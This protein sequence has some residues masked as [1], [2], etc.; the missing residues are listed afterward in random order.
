MEFDEQ[1]SQEE[2]PGLGEQSEQPTEQE[3]STQHSIVNQLVENF[4]EERD[5]IETARNSAMQ[6]FINQLSNLVDEKEGIIK[7]MRSQIQQRDE[8]ISNIKNQINN[9]LSGL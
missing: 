9:L 3:D 8:Q 2:Q 4:S 1:P 7:E 6:T 5:K